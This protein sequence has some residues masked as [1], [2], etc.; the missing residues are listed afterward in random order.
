MGR[1]RHRKKLPNSISWKKEGE[2]AVILGAPIGNGVNPEEY[3]ETKV[4]KMLAKMASWKRLRYKR[5]REK[6]RIEATLSL[7][8][9]WY[10][11]QHMLMPRKTRIKIVQEMDTMIWNRD[12]KPTP[13]KPNQTGGTD[14]TKPRIL[15]HWLTKRAM[16]TSPKKGGAGRLPIH[17]QLRAMPPSTAVLTHFYPARGRVC[18]CGTPPTHRP[19]R[20][21]SCHRS[22]AYQL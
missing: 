2:F 9:L 4:N 3:W 13:G 21:S 17:T 18:R 15:R 1:Y 12:P 11:A 10:T 5:F 8:L 6:N 7:S 20:R 19:G 22:P 14:Q 16:S